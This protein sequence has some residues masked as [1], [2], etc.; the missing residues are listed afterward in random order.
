MADE[1]K[2][3]DKVKHKTNDIIMV[4]V[5]FKNPVNN[6]NPNAKDP[7]RPICRYIHPVSGEYVREL[8]DAFEL[9]KL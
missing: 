8:F 7:T 4:V 2:L 3:G 6:M 1:L 5:D 9:E